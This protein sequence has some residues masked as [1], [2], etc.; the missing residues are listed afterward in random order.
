GLGDEAGID[1]RADEIRRDDEHIEPIAMD[2]SAKGKMGYHSVLV[3]KG[4]SD[5]ADMEGLA[6][7][8]LAFADPNS[9][10]GFMI[11]NYWLR[12]LGKIGGES[13][14]FKS[15]G[16]SGSHENGILAVMNGTYDVAATWT[17]DEED[18]NI[19]RMIRKG[20]INEG[21]VKVIWTSPLIPNSPFTVVKSLPE[22]MKADLKAAMTEMNTRD[23]ERFEQV[24]QGEFQR[25][26]EATHDMYVYA[27]ELREEQKKQR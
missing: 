7:K 20:M 17:Y 11:P 3:V 24:S 4:D 26:A 25:F 10:S 21:D 2:V 15:T 13:E 1:H 9:T 19:S 22:D 5:V 8:S 16:F 12:K 23:P 6:G 18:G 14:F 27:I